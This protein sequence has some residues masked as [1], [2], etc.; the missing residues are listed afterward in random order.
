MRTWSLVIILA[1]LSACT[2]T[3]PVRSVPT[4]PSPEAITAHR[5]LCI[6]KSIALECAKYAY[7]IKTTDI[8]NSR[9]FYKKACDLG[10]KSAC[11][12]LESI[13]DGALTANLN[14]ISSKNTALYSCYTE[15]LLK[16]QPTKFYEISKAREQEGK[17]T[18]Y[19]NV[20]VDKM[21]KLK[22]IELND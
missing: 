6:T 10:E 8:V 4:K 3:K 1:L 19:L 2:S 5:T 12:N 18:M 20:F 11:Y 16:I 14:L 17:R 15:H 22:K 7:I 21:G 9:F 13:E